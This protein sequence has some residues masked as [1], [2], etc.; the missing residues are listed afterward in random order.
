MQVYMQLALC[1]QAPQMTHNIWVKTWHNFQV[2][3]NFSFPSLHGKHDPQ[4]WNI[5]SP[6][7]YQ[8][9]FS[10]C[11]GMLSDSAWY[12]QPPTPSPW[13]IL[14]QAQPYSLDY[15]KSLV[16]YTFFH[17]NPHTNSSP[18]MP[19][20]H[21]YKQTLPSVSNLPTWLVCPY[22][23]AN[24]IFKHLINSL[25]LPICMRMIGSAEV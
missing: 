9:R 14:D 20:V 23:H 5:C 7:S 11:H 2:S 25:C 10:V 24:H 13:A 22:I 21:C 17:T 3:R 8:H 15:P 16:S 12:L 4:Q 1:F 18:R 6:Y 19:T